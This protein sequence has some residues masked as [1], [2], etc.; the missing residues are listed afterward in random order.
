MKQMMIVVALIAG[1]LPAVA[2]VLPKQQ[3]QKCSVAEWIW[4]TLVQDI[5]C[6]LG[7]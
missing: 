6:T 7:D 4:D 5:G 1:S 3:V 2:S